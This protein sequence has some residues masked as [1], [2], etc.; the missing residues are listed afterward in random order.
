VD[1]D[2]SNNLFLETVEESW[3]M[4]S[5][6]DALI[7][8]SALK[9]RRYEKF[10][11]NE[12]YGLDLIVKYLLE[13]DPR[14][15]L[16]FGLPHSVCFGHQPEWYVYGKREV[17]KTLVYFNSLDLRVIKLKKCRGWIAQFE[18]LFLTLLKIVDFSAEYG[19]KSLKNQLRAIFFPPHTNSSW[20]FSNNAFDENSINKL[21][22]MHSQYENIDV[23][24][25]LDSIISGRAHTYERAGFQVLS[26]GSTKDSKFL[27][28]WINLVSSYQNVI[29]ANLGSHVFYSLAMGKQIT[30]LLGKDFL[31]PNKI[32]ATSGKTR[33]PIV[34]FPEANRLL[35]SLQSPEKDVEFDLRFWMGGELKNNLS[36][37]KDRIIE[38]H[39]ESKKFKTKFFRPN[40]RPLI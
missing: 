12:Y 10:Y 2:R 38:I 29:T 35:A 40:L 14:E 36:E 23:M 3:D 18:N 30:W 6:L 25:P 20:G 19:N 21:I 1:L 5:N 15:S 28:R 9:D 16:P 8:R 4:Q 27:S 22:S 37:T 39:K 7:S 33:S 32:H 31:P 34:L 26:A 13:V 24:L 11:P 17:V